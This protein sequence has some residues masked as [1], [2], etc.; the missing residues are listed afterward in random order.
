MAVHGQ[1]TYAA[2]VAAFR[3]QLPPGYAFPKQRPGDP[4]A[5]GD[6]AGTD[7]A[8][9]VVYRWWRC[10][11]AE[12]AR[13]AEV[14]A[15]DYA[16]AALLLAQIRRVSDTDLPGN[17]EWVRNTIDTAAPRTFNA[18]LEGETGICWQWRTWATRSD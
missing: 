10:A 12:A 1:E 5:A 16:K 7:A 6:R 4:W 18:A 13:D 8:T 3:L 15:G 9:V 17:S 2:A 14:H 11:V